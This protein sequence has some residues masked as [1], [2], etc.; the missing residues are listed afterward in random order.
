MNSTTPP[1]NSPLNSPKYFPVSFDFNSSLD[2]GMGFS[3]GS[4]AGVYNQYSHGGFHRNDGRLFE[5][6]MCL[7]KRFNKVGCDPYRCHYNPNPDNCDNCFDIPNISGNPTT[8]NEPIKPIKNNFIR[9]ALIYIIFIKMFL[10]LF[11]LC[12]LFLK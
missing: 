11:Y 8:P 3:Q 10:F 9:Q 1:P 6:N 2:N 5:S 12:Y 4:T 7:R